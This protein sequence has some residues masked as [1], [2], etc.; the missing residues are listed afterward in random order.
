MRILAVDDDPL[1][2]D[3]LAASLKQ[4]GFTDVTYA[5]CAE[6]AI[7]LIDPA[8]VPVDS[9]FLDIMLPGNSGIE[10]CANSWSEKL[11]RRA[12]HHDYR[13]KGP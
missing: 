4:C 13:E 8:T 1:I 10:L 2:L 3:I 11:P 6:T 9:F 5:T 7:D 12:D